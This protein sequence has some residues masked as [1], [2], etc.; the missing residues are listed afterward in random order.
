[1]RTCGLDSMLPLLPN[2]NYR[3]NKHTTKLCYFMKNK[4]GS[5]KDRIKR[6]SV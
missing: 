5:C 1:M 6:L 3:L 4:N 2:N